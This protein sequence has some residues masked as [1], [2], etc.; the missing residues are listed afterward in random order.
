MQ[1]DGFQ[2]QYDELMKMMSRPFAT[3]EEF[4]VNMVIYGFDIRLPENFI[5]VLSLL[6]PR[7]SNN[8]DYDAYTCRNMLAKRFQSIMLKTEDF[9][10]TVNDKTV[11]KFLIETILDKNFK[12]SE[13]FFKII[14]ILDTTYGCQYRSLYFKRLYV[15]KSKH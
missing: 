12:P 4:M 10:E 6:L 8:S 5:I 1:D 3:D 15:R 2:L 14:K 9:A 13:F 7:A 11:E